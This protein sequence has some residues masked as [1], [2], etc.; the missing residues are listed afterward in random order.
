MISFNLKLIT[1]K[2]LQKYL[3][4]VVL[5]EKAFIGIWWIIVSS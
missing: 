2:L 5:F 4:F 3:S 1:S